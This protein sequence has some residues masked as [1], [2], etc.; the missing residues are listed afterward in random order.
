MIVPLPGGGAVAVAPYIGYRGFPVRHR[1]WAGVYVLHQDGRLED[2][3]PREALARPDLVAS[4]RLFPERLA[5]QI[6][7]AYGY[8]SRAGAVWTNHPRTEVSDPSGNPQ[9]YLTNVGGGR[10]DWVTVAHQAGDDGTVA[11][12]FLTDASTGATEVWKPPPDQRILSNTGAVALVRHLP[13]DWTGCCDDN[14]DEYWLLKAVDP[15]V[16][17]RPPVLLGRRD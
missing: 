16:R 6:G 11:A 13:L 5:R 8:R 7:S 3:S 10:I 4:G 2:L 15:C 12:I 17:E 9:P 14:G 1:Y